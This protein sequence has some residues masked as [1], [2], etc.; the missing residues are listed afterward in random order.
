VARWGIGEQDSRGEAVVPARASSSIEA[1][2]RVTSRTKTLDTRVFASYHGV[3]PTMQQNVMHSL[4]HR[5]RWYDR[6]EA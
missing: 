3:H 6:I 5:V 2:D 4:Q 1:R